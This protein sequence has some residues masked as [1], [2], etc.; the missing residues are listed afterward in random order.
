MGLFGLCPG[1]HD[2]N[3]CSK[4]WELACLVTIM[5]ISLACCILSKAL[6]A[7]LHQ[8]PSKCLPKPGMSK[9]EQRG[10]LTKKL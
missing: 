9:K 6:N 1:D 3:V 8:A 2:S 4:H 7:S 10:W 5:I